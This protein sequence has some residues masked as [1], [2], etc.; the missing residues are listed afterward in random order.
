MRNNDRGEETLYMTGQPKTMRGAV[1]ADLPVLQA[2][3]FDFAI[4]LRSAR[5]LGIEVPPSVLAIADGVIE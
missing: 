2:T 5:K 3:K 4:N 1:P